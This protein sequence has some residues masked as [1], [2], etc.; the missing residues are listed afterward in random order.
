[1]N[2]DTTPFSKYLKSLRDASGYTLRQVQKETGISNTYVS[3][4]ENGKKTSPSIE[5]IS[6]L[7]RVYGKGIN[8]SEVYRNLLKLAGYNTDFYFLDEVTKDKVI[9]QLDLLSD[10]KGYFFDHLK[11]DIFHAIT[12]EHF[13]ET[14]FPNPFNKK[15]YKDIYLNFFNNRDNKD[16]QTDEEH[17]EIIKAFDKTYNVETITNVLEIMIGEQYILD[18]FNSALHQIIKKHNIEADNA[19]QI[20]T[21]LHKFISQDNITYKEYSLTDKDKTIITA[22]L[23]GFFSN[24]DR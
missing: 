18:N 21:D 7:A 10:D 13:S 14:D 8:F 3:N 24:S 11:S 23:D 19:E 12:N 4:L 16:F 15:S 6:A 17:K 20:E 5:T 1:M 2:L 22:Y 9:K